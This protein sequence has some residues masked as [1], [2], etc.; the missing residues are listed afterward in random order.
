[1]GKWYYMSFINDYSHHA[2][3]YLLHNKDKVFKSFQHYL[4]TAPAD[5]KGRTL[6][7]DQGGEYKSVAMAKYLFNKG[8]VHK[9]TTAC[10]LEHNGV[11][12]H[13]NCTIIKMVCCMLLNTSLA[14]TFWGEAVLTACAINNWLPTTANNF[15]AP[16]DRWDNQHRPQAEISNLHHFS[17]CV[18]V[19]MNPVSCNKL[20]DHT[21]PGIY[22]GPTQANA[23][24]HQVLISSK[25]LKTHD[26]MFNDTQTSDTDIAKCAE[27]DDHVIITELAGNRSME[28]QDHGL[29]NPSS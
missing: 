29:M 17:S 18:Q 2:T 16:M 12:E 14:K 11:A 28:A 26:V 4:D 20:A 13:F 8:I 10:M 23:S 3:I 27:S 15:T 7:S 9:T 6:Q 1:M 21:C 24:H 19:L 22:L 5:W 25:V